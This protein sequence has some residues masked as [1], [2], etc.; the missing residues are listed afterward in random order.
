MRSNEKV[1]DGTRTKVIRDG[2][3]GREVEL[4]WRRPD[5][6]IVK[7]ERDPED[8][9]DPRAR[10]WYKSALERRGRV[11]TE[12]YIFFTSRKPGITVASPIMGK[13]GVVEAVLGADIEISD[14]SQFL[15][16][17]S[18]LGGQSVYISTPEGKVIAHS[19]AN[20]I[21]SDSA[22]GE[23]ALRFRLISELPGIEGKAGKRLS[24]LTGR[25]SASV[26]E[27]E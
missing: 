17:A 3:R 24:E 13:D 12:P 23:N 16:R 26:W 6:A 2:P 20:V 21:V 9:Y 18:L 19:N 11:W 25:R 27:E 14:I 10:G 5:Y 1:E 22:G 4:T 15:A 7:S 8:T